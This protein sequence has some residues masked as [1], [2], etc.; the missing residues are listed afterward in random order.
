MLGLVLSFSS[1]ITLRECST[2][3]NSRVLESKERYGFSRS[4]LLSYL[5]YLLAAHVFVKYYL[6]FYAKKIYSL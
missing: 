2:F 6:A 1:R 3:M 5:C 4:V